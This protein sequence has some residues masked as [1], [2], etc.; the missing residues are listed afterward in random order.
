MGICHGDE[1]QVGLLLVIECNLEG[2]VES[3]K[4]VLS[5]LVPETKFVGDN[6]VGVG[7]ITSFISGNNVITGR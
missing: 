7:G 5:I 6:A 3:S 1:A 2:I 4:V